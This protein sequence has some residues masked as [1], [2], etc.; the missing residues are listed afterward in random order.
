VVS[1]EVA[2]RPAGFDNDAASLPNH[3]PRL[4]LVRHQAAAVE[5]FQSIPNDESI[6]VA[7]QHNVCRPRLDYTEMDVERRSS[8]KQIG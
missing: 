2:A 5:W 7:L 8:S 1:R 3:R 4:S 6:T